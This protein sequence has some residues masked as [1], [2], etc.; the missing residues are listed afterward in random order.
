MIPMRLDLKSESRDRPAWFAVD[1]ILA[2]GLLVVLALELGAGLLL[3]RSDA[4]LRARAAAGRPASERAAAIHRLLARGTLDDAER[5]ELHDSLQDGPAE[6]AEFVE[7]SFPRFARE[8]A[9]GAEG[10][11]G[12]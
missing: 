8:G 5:A 2:L 1:A 10:E 4:E 12:E 3:T 6:L 7:R 11:D 9:G